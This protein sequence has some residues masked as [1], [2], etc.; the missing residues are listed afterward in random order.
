MK[1]VKR[2]SCGAFH[3][4]GVTGIMK[5]KVLKPDLLSHL[6]LMVLRSGDAVHMGTRVLRTVRTWIGEP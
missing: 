2:I 3:S 5:L 4:A 6:V 1:H